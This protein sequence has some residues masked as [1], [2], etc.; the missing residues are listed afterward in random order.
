[1]PYNFNVNV[2][3]VYPDG[4]EDLD[5]DTVLSGDSDLDDPYIQAVILNSDGTQS[6]DPE[7]S[8]VVGI[9]FREKMVLDPDNGQPIISVNTSDM[10]RFGSEVESVIRNVCDRYIMLQHSINFSEEYDDPE[11]PNPPAEE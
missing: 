10:E 4:W 5:V 11:D 7:L 2:S 9:P 6:E 3:I 8:E 1:M